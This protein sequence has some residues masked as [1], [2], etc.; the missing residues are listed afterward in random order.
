MCPP[1]SL[2]D[3]PPDAYDEPGSEGMPKARRAQRR[4]AA[5]VVRD[6]MCFKRLQDRVSLPPMS[7]QDGHLAGVPSG[8]GQWLDGRRN[9]LRL[10]LPVLGRKYAHATRGL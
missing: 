2:G 1:P 5:A 4:A 10:L 8:C 6:L 9:M 3:G 7:D